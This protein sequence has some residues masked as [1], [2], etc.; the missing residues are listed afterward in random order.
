ME[1][2]GPV[3]RDQ[4]HNADVRTAAHRRHFDA[5]G[6]LIKSGR[7]GGSHLTF[8]GADVRITNDAVGRDIV[9]E[10]P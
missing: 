7:Q 1:A 5:A 3:K 8:G 6:G 10:I 2:R 9:T 4:S